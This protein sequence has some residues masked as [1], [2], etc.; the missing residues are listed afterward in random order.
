M[1]HVAPSTIAS[2]QQVL[3]QSGAEFIPN[4]VRRRPAP[5]RDPA[6][7]DDLRAISITSAPRNYAAAPY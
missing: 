7:F 1:K 4:G 6:L 3:E 5:P 2:I